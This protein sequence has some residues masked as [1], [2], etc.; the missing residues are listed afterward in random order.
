[1]ATSPAHKFG[2]LVGELLEEMIHPGLKEFC[3]GRGL[4]L[5]TPGARQAR[6][7]KKVTWTDNFGNK[8]DL[9]FVIEK[10]GTE[11]RRGRPVAFIEAA[12]RRYTKHSKNKAQEIQ[13]AVL[14]LAEK[15]GW[16]KPFLGV[17][18]AGEFTEAAVE[19]LK[20]LGFNVLHIPYST[21]VDAFAGVGIDVRFDERTPDEDFQA[22][23]EKVE[24]LDDDQRGRFE[25]SVGG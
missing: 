11:A 13:G 17:A 18:L 5:D 20:S 14:P 15:H 16:D 8:H 3:E 9:D 19:Q 21:V 24:G 7:G 12:W 25:S 2:Q 23:V 1:M 4:Y 10:D 22:C 6:S